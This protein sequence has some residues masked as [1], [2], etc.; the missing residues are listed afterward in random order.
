V[1]LGT[2]RIIPNEEKH[3]AP[4]VVVEDVCPA[5]PGAK[6]WQPAAWSPRTELLYVPHQHLCSTFAVSEV[7]YI[8][9]TPF[10]GAT[11]DMYAAAGDGYRGEFMAS[12]PVRQEKVWAIRENFPVW[13]GAAATAGD[14][15]FYGTID[16]LANP[17][18][19]IRFEC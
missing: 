13:S 8:A 11:V 5:P 4:G 12:D 17:Q 3:P 1:D 15:V 2:G 14:M 19:R 16:R 18:E 7:G 9:G 6:D 10:L